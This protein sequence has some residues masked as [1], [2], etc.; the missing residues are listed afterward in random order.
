MNT[1]K[2]QDDFIQAMTTI[3]TAVIAVAGLIF[4]A[5]LFV[6]GQGTIGGTLAGLI[7]GYYFSTA[8][9]ALG[10]G[11]THATMRQV[12]RLPKGENEQAE[13]IKE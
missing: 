11:Q 10:V 8:G 4:S 7:L 9:A 13:K 6:N 5:F 12:A 3:T 1:R 2:N